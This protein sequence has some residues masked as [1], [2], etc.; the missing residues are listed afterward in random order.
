MRTRT[1]L[2]RGTLLLAA[3]IGTTAAGLRFWRLGWGL[4]E[5]AGFPD[6]LFSFNIYARAFLSLSCASFAQRTPLYPTFYGYLL[7][8]ATAL[9]HALGL[10][11]PGLPNGAASPEVFVA[12]RTISALMGVA[13][14]GVVGVLG[15]RMY[16]RPVGLAA[17]ALTAVLPFHVLYTHLGTTDAT[18]T[19]CAAFTLAAAYAMARGQG[20]RVAAVAGAAAAL[21]FATKY[22]GLAMS[23]AVGWAVLERA[24]RDGP[25]RGV[26]LGLAA[27]AGF[28]AAFALACPPCVFDTGRMLEGMRNLQWQTSDLAHGAINNHLSPTVGWYARPYLYQLV[29]SLPFVLGWPLH[30][31]A[32]A[33]VVVAVRRH[34]L[35]DR[36]LLVSAGSYF[37]AIG[38]SDVVFPRYLMPLF[39]ALAILAARAAWRLPSRPLGGAVLAAVWAYSLVL[40]ASQVARFS[41]DQQREVARW[42]R[43]AAGERKGVRVGVPRLILDYFRLAKP[44]AEAGLVQI[45]LESGHWFDEPTDFLVLPEWYGTAIA[46]DMP[47]QPIARDLERLRSGAAGYRRGPHWSSTYFQHAFYTRLDPAF[48]TD[49]WQGEI[50]FTVYVRE[51]V[52]TGSR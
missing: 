49:L 19:A 9:A 30:L 34:D 24:Y 16:S 33:G 31:L 39:P 6:E 5:Q 35:A 4:P 27:L 17:A 23:V 20:T 15:A 1:A 50:G 29:A 37:L 10:T 26:V 8:L 11:T 12:G 38:A 7:G 14:V 51:P 3:G 13:T 28:A 42:I 25:R 21:A 40:S 22:T 48:A 47:D 43:S 2:S 52:R 18:L 41:Y 44:L 36:M 46:R 45:Q 32:M